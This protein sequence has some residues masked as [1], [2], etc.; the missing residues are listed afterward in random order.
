MKRFLRAILRRC[1]HAACWAVALTF[2]CAIHT[3]AKLN[4][5]LE[6]TA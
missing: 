5:W 3:F 6:D 4:H 2:A 1:E